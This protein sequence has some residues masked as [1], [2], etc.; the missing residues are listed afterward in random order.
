MSERV[1]RC[2]RKG[3]REER[4]RLRERGKRDRTRDGDRVKSIECSVVSV[5]ALVCASGCV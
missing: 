3:D 2:V 5:Y 1:C 4:Q